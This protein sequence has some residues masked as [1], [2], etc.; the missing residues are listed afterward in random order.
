MAAR[1]GGGGMSFH[2]RAMA[3][4]R[5]EKVADPAIQPE[6]GAPASA[7]PLRDPQAVIAEAMAQSAPKPAAAPAAP[8]R[9]YT[10]LSPQEEYEQR[11]AAMNAK[12]GDQSFLQQALARHAA[13]EGG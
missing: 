5:G 6:R 3:R 13:R 1:S 10:G 2:E 4:S 9:P 7:R 11:R 12:A 8:A